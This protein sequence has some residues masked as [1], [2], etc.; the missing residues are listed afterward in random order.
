MT[1]F[2]AT[3]AFLPIIRLCS[4]NKRRFTTAACQ[5]I[6]LPLSNCK[7]K[8]A[9]SAGAAGIAQFVIINFVTAFV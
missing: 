6:R 3:L 9:A 5:H 4:Y 1:I 7:A 2:F 8:N